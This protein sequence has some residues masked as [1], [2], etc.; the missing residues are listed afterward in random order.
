M[1]RHSWAHAWQARAQ[2]WQWSMACLA[3]SSPQVWQTS[4]H[5][6]QIV[7]AFSL[8]RA[9]AGAATAQIW[10]Q[11]M[12]SAIHRAIIFTSGSCRHEAAQWLHAMAQALQASMQAAWTW[13]GISI[14]LVNGRRRPALRVA[15]RWFRSC[16]RRPR[17]PVIREGVLIFLAALCSFWW[18]KSSTSCVSGS[19][20]YGLCGWALTIYSARFS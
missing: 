16:S 13:C 15:V 18:V 4:A 20:E 17:V 14:S 11:S 5:A 1:F 9:I 6:L 19:Y 7:L 10:A 3:H 12:S 8:P 2:A